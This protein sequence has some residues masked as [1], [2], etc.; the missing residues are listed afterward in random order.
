ME[1]S[2]GTQDIIACLGYL[3]LV[4]KNILA[5]YLPCRDAGNT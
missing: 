5:M 3:T 2:K 1:R 4:M